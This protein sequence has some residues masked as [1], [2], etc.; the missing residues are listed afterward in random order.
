MWI[1]LESNAR[2][3]ICVEINKKIPGQWCQL[4]AFMH[5]GRNVAVES[6]QALVQCDPMNI[7][8]EGVQDLLSFETT[9]SRSKAYYDSCNPGTS[10]DI[11]SRLVMLKT[12]SRASCAHKRHAIAATRMKS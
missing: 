12:M 10:D 11:F 6:F 3:Q 5:S 9:M 4:L 7:S 8:P 1:N 2:V